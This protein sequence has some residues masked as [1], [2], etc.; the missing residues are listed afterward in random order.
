MELSPRKVI[1]DL[2]K[3]GIWQGELS[4]INKQGV[5]KVILHTASYLVN[6][7]GERIS[8]ISTGKD[9]TEKKEAEELFKSI[10]LKWLCKTIGFEKLVIK[11]E[12]MLGFFIPNEQST[13]FQS[14]MFRHLLQFVNENNFASFKEKST[15][16]SQNKQLFLRF[17]KITSIEVAYNKLRTIVN[18]KPH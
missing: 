11:D 1:A 13:Y 8:I 15:K 14:T 12:V 17:E 7:S 3:K 2:E 5:R 6:E 9:I 18:A 16:E 10:E 4:F